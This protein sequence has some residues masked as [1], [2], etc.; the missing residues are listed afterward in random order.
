MQKVL[1]V[2]SQIDQHAA[3]NKQDSLLYKVP[4]L[5]QGQP[6]P[7]GD[8][9][10]WHLNQLPINVNPVATVP[11]L[12]PGSTRGSRHCIREEDLANIVQQYVFQDPNPLQGPIFEL[13]GPIIIEHPEHDDQLWQYSQYIAI[14]YQRRYAK[15]DLRRI[16][17]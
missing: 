17:D 15:E 1:D 6:I 9:N 16:L 14:T 3:N 11:Q 8:I 12:A 7:Q 5:K 13:S 2:L 4:R 10:I